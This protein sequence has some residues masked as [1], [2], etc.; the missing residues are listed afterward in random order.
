[1]FVTTFGNIVGKNADRDWPKRNMV[2]TRSYTLVWGGA[3]GTFR[4]IRNTKISGD[5]L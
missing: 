5:D 1:M 4:T 2:S 3:S